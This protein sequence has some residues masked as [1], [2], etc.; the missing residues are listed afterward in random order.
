MNRS[1]FPSEDAVLQPSSAFRTMQIIRIMYAVPDIPLADNLAQ[2]AEE[3]TDVA[4]PID[5]TIMCPPS[6][7]AFPERQIKNAVLV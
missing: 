6:R 7:T 3:M 2:L 5:G 1:K 4:C